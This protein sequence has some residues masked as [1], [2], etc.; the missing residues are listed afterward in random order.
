MSLR[1]NTSIQ[2]DFSL[3]SVEQRKEYVEKLID[4]LAEKNYTP[5]ESEL[6]LFSNYIL[7]GKD[8]DGTSIVDRKEVQIATK[9]NTYKK[10]ADQSLEELS[11]MPG[12]NES[13]ALNNTPIQ[14]KTK[15]V[16]FDREKSKDIKELYPLFEQ[17]DD[18]NNLL[19]AYENKLEHTEE[20]EKYYERAKQLTAQKV[21]KM[22]HLLVELRREQYTIRDF[23][24]PT[25]QPLPV[26][27]AYRGGE[28][29]DSIPW[30]EG[31]FE[32]APLGFY[33]H[34]LKRFEDPLRA[35]EKD[36][37]FNNEAKIILDFRNP[38]HLYS[39]FDM[40][41]E[42][43]TATIDNPESS[44]I[45]LLNTVKFYVEHSPLTDEQRDILYYKIHK[46]PNSEIAN[47][48]NKKYNTNH[49][50][51]Y[52]STIYKQKICTEIA[53]YVSF[54]YDEYLARNDQFRWKKCITCGKVKLKDP[55]N[56]VRKVRSSD[57]LANRCKECDKIY[58]D[59]KGGKA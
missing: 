35:D 54:H 37:K 12:F 32:V 30:Q 46:I 15:K 2:L 55:R 49:T 53:S 16:K 51:N 57:G 52:I 7:Y 3:S 23:Y 11:E 1:K 20:N 47:I 58:R 29:D 28:Q 13:V 18:I 9:Y 34:G 50:L 33:Y 24:H 36:Y 40:W 5:V 56:F 27:A 17:I 45:P 44:L 59:T 14:Y 6:E 4:K 22:K 26:H 43:E 38:E 39:I 10:K 48:I 21:Y 19:Q 42:L 31:D 8:E 25:L 41:L